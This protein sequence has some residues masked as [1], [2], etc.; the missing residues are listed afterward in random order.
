MVPLA[1]VVRGRGVTK[2]TT[3]TVTGVE[4]REVD[5]LESHDAIL[6]RAVLHDSLKQMSII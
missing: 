1:T 3:K 6:V 4:R 2:K 5:A